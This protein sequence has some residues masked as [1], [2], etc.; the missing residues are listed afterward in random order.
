IAKVLQDLT[1]PTYAIAYAL[2]FAL[3][4][5]LGIV[6]EERLA[7]GTQ[8]VSLYTQKGG[9][10]ARSLLAAG[11]RVAQVHEHLR[12]GGEEPMS[13]LY[14]ELPRRQ[15]R[16]LIRDAAAIDDRCFCVIN[17]VR[18]AR[19]AGTPPS[20]SSSTSRRNQ[21]HPEVVR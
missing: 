10:L 3:G 7:F 20:G 16:L 12:G 18:L 5:Y 17:D 4:T 11:H 21:F 2:G 13:I 14:V 19:Y 6:V 9:E 15:V 8:V 1:H